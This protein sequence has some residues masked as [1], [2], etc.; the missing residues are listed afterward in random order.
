MF[1]CSKLRCPCTVFTLQITLHLNHFY[2]TFTL[3]LRNVYSVFTT[4]VHMYASKTGTFFLMP[5]V[6]I[7]VCTYVGVYVHT[8]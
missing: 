6:C 8:S 5:T 1:L 2:A 3:F 7:H 4:F